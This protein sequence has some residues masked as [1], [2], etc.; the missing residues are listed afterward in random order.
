METSASVGEV[1]A[2]HWT[3]NGGVAFSGWAVALLVA[4]V[5]QANN[6]MGQ[7]VGEKLEVRKPVAEAPDAAGNQGNNKAAGENHPHE[8]AVP[9]IDGSDRF[10]EAAGKIAANNAGADIAFP[11]P[12]PAGLEVPDHILDAARGMGRWVTHENGSRE[13]VETAD[14]KTFEAGNGWWVVTPN[15]IGW[16]DN[17][18]ITNA[19]GQTLYPVGRALVLEA[20]VKAAKAELAKGSTR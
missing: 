5:A 11:F 17:S 6:L 8:E 1:K 20:M 2:V 18:P 9:A 15:R 7:R 19:A 10:G 4:A 16:H 14:V 12:I 13:F 3:R